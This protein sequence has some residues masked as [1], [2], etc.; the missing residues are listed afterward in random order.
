MPHVKMFAPS[1]D[2]HGSVACSNDHVW[3]LVRAE[4]TKDVYAETYDTDPSAASIVPTTKLP[5]INGTQSGPPGKRKAFYGLALFIHKSRGGQFWVKAK[6]DPVGG[7]K[8]QT[9]VIG[10]F[11]CR[12]VKTAGESVEVVEPSDPASPAGCSP[13]TELVWVQA[14][15]VGSTGVEAVYAATFDSTGAEPSDVEP[16]NGESLGEIVNMP[17]MYG[18]MIAKNADP[19]KVKAKA[20]FYPAGASGPTPAPQ[21]DVSVAF[22]C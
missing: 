11:T 10:P 7:G 12:P 1:K 18:G 17:D 6:S 2:S 20:T 14:R 3:V 19:F 22:H 5:R 15:A 13:V 21:F 8:S 4:A 9:E 16:P